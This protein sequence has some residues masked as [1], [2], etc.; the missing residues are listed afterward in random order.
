M[1]LE[2]RLPNPQIQIRRI[3]EQ[4]FGLVVRR[5][6]ADYLWMWL[7]DAGREYG[8]VFHKERA[9]SRQTDLVLATYNNSLKVT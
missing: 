9:T 8:V 5:S 7:M 6:F 4:S 2:L 3:G 1:W